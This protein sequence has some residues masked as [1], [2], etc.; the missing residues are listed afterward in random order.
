MLCT[1]LIFPRGE[2]GLPGPHCRTWEGW[3]SAGVRRYDRGWTRGAVNRAS[4]RA[5]DEP[6]RSFT[7]RRRPL[8]GPS[9]GW[10]CLVA[11]SAST[12][13][14]L[15]HYQPIIFMNAGNGSVWLPHL[16]SISC[17]PLCFK[18]KIALYQ[19]HYLHIS[20]M[21]LVMNGY[22][23]YLV[24]KEGALNYSHKVFLDTMLSR[25]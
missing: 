22:E 10:K 7:I 14:N 17:E 15:R 16:S 13:K 2:A 1:V 20:C 18:Y 8:Q 6:S 5:R 24:W 4:S 3:E 11:S 21:K 23:E 25:C 12:F 9:S 19:Q